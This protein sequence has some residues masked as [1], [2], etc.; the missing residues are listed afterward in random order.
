VFKVLIRRMK[1]SLLATCERWEAHS[2][3]ISR[4][5]PYMYRRTYQSCRHARSSNISLCP[6]SRTCEKNPDGHIPTFCY[7][8]NSGAV[9]NRT[10]SPPSAPYLKPQQK[11]Q[12][13]RRL[14]ADHASLRLH[15]PLQDLELQNL[16]DVWGHAA[17]D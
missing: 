2:N 7:D 13:L 16:R 10:R 15:G 17:K 9:T 11:R 4:T 12:V 14:P 6:F 8:N 3:Y 1:R 5:Y